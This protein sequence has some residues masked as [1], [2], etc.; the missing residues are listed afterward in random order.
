MGVGVVG[1]RRWGWVQYK[2]VFKD[3][4]LNVDWI[5][6]MREKGRVSHRQGTEEQNKVLQTDRPTEMDAGLRKEARV[7]NT[8]KQSPINPSL[9]GQTPVVRLGGRAFTCR[10][11]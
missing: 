5:W 3:S 9:R 6:R 4:E 7:S 1:G 8:C 10:L 2:A 11:D